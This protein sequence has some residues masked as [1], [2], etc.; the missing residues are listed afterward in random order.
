MSDS[1]PAPTL[2][3]QAGSSSS[4][5]AT[6]FLNTQANGHDVSAAVRTE[7]ANAV[8]QAD[9][10]VAESTMAPSKSTAL[11]APLHLHVQGSVPS[12]S[13]SSSTAAGPASSSSPLPSRSR[14]SAENG[15]GGT[16]C[17]NCGTMTTPLWRRTPEGL[18]VCNACG[19]LLL[20]SRT[21]REANVQLLLFRDGTGLYEK[22]HGS[23]RVISASEQAEIDAQNGLA[24]HA[25][26]SGK[27]KLWSVVTSKGE[28][29]LG[30][31][32]AK[33]IHAKGTC[34]GDGLCD[35]TG[36][37]ASCNGCPAFNNHLS[38]IKKHQQPAK[39]PPPPSSSSAEAGTADSRRK[40]A[41]SEELGNPSTPTGALVDG[42]GVGE[43]VEG[44]RNEEGEAINEDYQL[45]CSNCGTNTTPLWRRDEEGNNIC[46]ACGLYHK[47]HGTQRPINMKKSVIKR[48]KRVPAAASAGTEGDELLVAPPSPGTAATT[49][50][51]GGA[52][53]GKNKEP[54]KQSRPRKKLVDA[55]SDGRDAD[56]EAAM[57]LMEVG[58]A[59]SQPGGDASPDMIGPFERASKKAR[60][61][62]AAADSPQQPASPHPA[63]EHVSSSAA[64]QHH[65]HRESLLGV[66]PIEFVG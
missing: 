18:P 55:T 14:P 42:S 12:S 17:I 15:F 39:A 30:T 33:Q 50:P 47:L 9:A 48:R 23:K 36:G 3:E 63:S 43:R 60:A 27:T 29:E 6:D 38:A 51:A 56:T 32:A 65:H 31:S 2:T 59:P 45:I 26:S 7:S 66:G 46:N 61:N 44:E 62:A 40:R 64:P 11:P 19:E 58:R 57:A 54:R 20:F 10:E 34:P 35:G 28:G 13:S 41:H 8:V 22:T 25:E 1:V 4:S 16:K 21:V 53:S 5:H 37:T 52:A 49:G 24:Q